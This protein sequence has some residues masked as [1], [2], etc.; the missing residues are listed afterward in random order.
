MN[1]STHKSTVL[2]ND[3]VE[4]SKIQFLSILNRQ[5]KTC[6]VTSTAGN[7]HITYCTIIFNS[8]SIKSFFLNL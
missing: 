3:T 5:L 1:R 8:L 6:Y 2:Q 7:L 4:V